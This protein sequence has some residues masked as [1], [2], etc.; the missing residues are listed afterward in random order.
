MGP[1]TAQRYM[2]RAT[3]KIVSTA[4]MIQRALDRIPQD[5][6]PISHPLVFTQPDTGRKALN[7]SP[8][9]AMYIEE[10]GEDGHELLLELAHHIIDGPAYHHKW[11]TDEMIL[12]DNWRM[13]HSVTPTPV[14]EER[15]MQR[16]TIQGDY[17]LGRT[18]E[19]PVAA[20]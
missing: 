20:E 6:P 1:F 16:T 11:T 2:T 10:L 9:F 15:V 14:D 4:P 5:F 17:G 8:F 19:F 7:L 3:V 12:W 13:L 18:L